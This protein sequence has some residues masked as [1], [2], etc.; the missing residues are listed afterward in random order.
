[1]S[2]LLSDGNTPASNSG[3]DSPAQKESDSASS[4]KRPFTWVD[5]GL[6]AL[7]LGSLGGLCVIGDMELQHAITF[8]VVGGL[9]TVELR[10]RLS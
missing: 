1:M 6:L 2:L 8:V 10:R 3:G 5:L 4:A 7:V 9:L